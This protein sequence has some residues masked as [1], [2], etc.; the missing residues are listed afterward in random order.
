MHTDEPKAQKVNKVLNPHK[1]S[2]FYYIC[3][4]KN[5]QLQAKKL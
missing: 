1:D 4:Y 5:K 3:G 2:L